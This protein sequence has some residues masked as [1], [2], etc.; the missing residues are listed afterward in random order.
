VWLSVKV[1][2]HFRSKLITNIGFGARNAAARLKKWRAKISVMLLRL[3]PFE[4]EPMLCLYLQQA[5]GKNLSD[6]DLDLL[7][8][9]SSKLAHASAENFQQWEDKVLSL[10]A[11]RAKFA[12]EI[13]L[14]D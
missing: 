2:I 3:L 13:A 11:F 10:I 8:G 1:S 9:I 12:E 5:S 7:D 6:P 4:P 14:S